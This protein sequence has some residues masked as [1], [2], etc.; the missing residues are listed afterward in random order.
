LGGETLAS[1]RTLSP[2]RDR[3]DAVPLARTEFGRSPMAPFDPEIRSN[4]VE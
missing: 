2:G 3:A 1:G 4:T